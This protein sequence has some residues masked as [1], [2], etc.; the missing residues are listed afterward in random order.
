MKKAPEGA[1]HNSICPHSEARKPLNRENT[2]PRWD[3]NQPLP[4]KFRHSPENIPSPAQSD[5]GA[6][7]SEAQGVDTV[8][9]L[10]GEHFEP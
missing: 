8:H 2:C 3:S 4:L 9:T 7:E 5:A 1:L 6:T 10:F